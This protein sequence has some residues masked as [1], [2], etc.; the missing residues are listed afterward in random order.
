MRLAAIA[1]AVAC[2]NPERAPAQPESPSAFQSSRDP[3][4]R[5]AAAALG[6]G[7]PWRAT[8][9]LDSAF[10][11]DS[12]RTAES[13][14]L[15][16][17]AAAAW[18]GWGRVER[19]LGTAPWVDSLFGGQG[20]ALLTR[21]A[22]ARGSDSLARS[23]AEL[24][25]RSAR[26]DRDRGIR[27]V[28]LARALDRLAVG[29]SAAATY[30]RSARLLP[31]VADWLQL[32]AAGVTAD[33]SARRRDYARVTNAI[34]RARVEP[35]EAQARERWGDF[36]GAAR[37]YA[38]LGQPGEA[39]R[40]RSMASRD[41]A[42]KAAVRS[43]AFA[44][45]RARPPAADVRV[46]VALVDSVV[47]P[48]SPDEDLVVARAANGAG[49]LQR[50]AAGFARSA[51][52][53][54]ADDRYA[55]GMALSRL[56]RDADAARE[57]AKVPASAAT[58]GAAAYQRARSLLRA[59]QGASS[60]AALRRVMTAFPNDTT[61][62][63]P[64][65]FLL[66]DLATDEGRDANART[67]FL[68][69]ARRY[70]SSTLAPVAQFRAGIIAYAAGNFARAADDLDALV[71]RFPRSTEI[72]AARYWA[73]R[74]R[75][76]SGD[77][78]RAAERW[79][80][81]MESDPLSYYSM[82]SA[83]RL[84]VAPWRPQQATDGSTPTAATRQAIERAELLDVLGMTTEEGFEYDA[85]ASAGTSPD[86]LIRAA[87][88]LRE[89]GQTSRAIALARRALAASAPRD[90][91]LFTL[92]YPIAFGDVIRSEAAARRIDAAL[93]AAL[94]HQESSFNP[95]AASR[96]GALGLMQVLPSVGASIARS[97]RVTPFERVLLFQPDVNI[98]LGTIHLDAMLDQYPNIELALAA[99]NAGGT[100]VRRWRQKAGTNDPEL[101]I[102]R[103]PYDETRDYVRILLRNQA[104]YKTL[105]GW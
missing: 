47:G 48:I 3:V 43:D 65:L 80:E 8:E 18:G 76:R 61:A 78:R 21:A 17:T 33:A 37:A 16:A 86:S 44:L 88:A 70:P 5:S 81:V 58:G 41:D 59:G 75:E 49:L 82:L 1:V 19:E 103:I 23:H 66:A 29:D 77:R 42:E 10:K 91:R 95:R 7:R 31:A 89:R 2:G 55:Y 53:L 25:I 100:P 62:A 83:R 14:L 51:A 87:E 69:V 94:I 93:V 60:R 20:R 90:T 9:L 96:A 46:T 64:A 36:A 28:L 68:D 13:I 52:S 15:A 54:T 57:L 92:L 4:V 45:L 11:R 39:L 32:R 40:L 73:G 98:R 12:T 50:A 102:E 72:S 26:T 30:R 34:A 24:A 74:A 79:R 97:S 6:A 38:E 67:A 22:L 35:S 71:Q 104:T 99:Y 27:L 85:L 63:A 84:G 101:F 56:G 105:Y